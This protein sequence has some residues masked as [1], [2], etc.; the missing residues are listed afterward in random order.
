MAWLCGLGTI[1]MA[2]AAA[3]ALASCVCVGCGSG[4]APPDH[5]D[6]PD[7]RASTI[8]VS[9]VTGTFTFTVDAPTPVPFND[10]ADARLML[11]PGRTRIALTR[12]DGGAGA[13]EVYSVAGALL[14]SFDASLELVGWAGEDAL[15]FVNK[16][17]VADVVRTNLDGSARTSFDFG[18]TADTGFPE[19]FAAATSRTGK[20][21][22]VSF[23]LDAEVLIVDTASGAIVQAYPIDDTLYPPALAWLYDDT[24]VLSAGIGGSAL[25][26]TKPTSSTI[27]KSAFPGSPCSVDSW[28]P[29]YPMLLGAYVTTGDTSACARR[30]AA[31]ANGSGATPLDWL[32]DPAIPGASSAA[33]VY[34]LSPDARRVVYQSTGAINIASPDG[35]SAMPLVPL[36]QATTLAW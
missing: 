36:Q 30:L 23:L 18:F 31:R 6:G 9:D 34:A 5:I 28:T 8:W 3:G 7:Y 4:A 32:T 24:L 33:A 22:A 14:G 13:T 15:V 27:S 35:T 11:S 12:W 25:A 21:L 29:A 16:N 1:V 10:R 26:T 2:V 20:Y 19:V 17:I